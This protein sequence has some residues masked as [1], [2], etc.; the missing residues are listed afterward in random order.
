MPFWL[1][2]TCVEVNNGFLGFILKL[3]KWFNIPKI[4]NKLWLMADESGVCFRTAES[5]CSLLR[6]RAVNSL[7][8][9]LLWITLCVSISIYEIQ[10][11]N[12]NILNPNW[13]LCFDVQRSIL[14]LCMYMHARGH[15][16]HRIFI[17]LSE[18]LL[19]WK[20]QYFNIYCVSVYFKF[21]RNN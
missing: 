12:V 16:S 17:T 10:I 11:D 6:A 2:G 9:C 21:V 3:Y 13:K 1:L 18:P 8:E 14:Y 5:S 4:L 19:E 7:Q 20:C 15:V